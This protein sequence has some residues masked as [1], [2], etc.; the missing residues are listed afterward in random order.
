MTRFTLIFLLIAFMST[1]MQYSASNFNKDILGTWIFDK[2]EFVFDANVDQEE[3]E[4][5]E[6]FMVPMLEEGLSY[7]QM[8]F[9]ADGTMRTIVDAPDE[10][11]EDNGSWHLSPDGKVLTMQYEDGTDSHDVHLLNASNMV[12]AVEDEGI[13][14]LMHL[15]KR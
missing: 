9:Y 6:V 15:K 8:S 2:I 12:L 1:S 14:L 7:V 3:R 11:S 13:K 10:S 5:I 4:F